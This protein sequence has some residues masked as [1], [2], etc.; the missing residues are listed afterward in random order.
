MFKLDLATM[1]LLTFITITIVCAAKLL[2]MKGVIIGTGRIGLFLYESNNKQDTLISRNSDS[3]SINE[4]SSGPIYVCTRNDDLLDVLNKTPKNRKGDLV[5]LQNGILEPFL[6]QHDLHENTQ[7]LI[8]FAISKKGETPIDGKTDL[9]PEGLTAVTGKWANDFQIRL[10]SVGLACHVLDKKN[11]EIA[12]FEKLIWI[13]AF[14]IVGAKHGGC[15]VG[16]VE[17]KYNQQVC[18]L[19][20]EMAET[21]TKVK[22]VEFSSNLENRLCAYARSVAHFPTALKEFKW[23]NGWFLDIS[24]KSL[25]DKVPDPCPTH[26]S[27]L[28]ELK[29]EL[30]V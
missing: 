14:M 23:R 18:Q 25:L 7:G 26:T 28:K 29:S 12:M 11:W 8:Y 2:P 19:V 30:F 16:E 10:N 1:L 24:K 15:T 4:D 6:H 13:S 3:S 21:V 27:Y 5:F 9:N 17:S 22:Q 20:R